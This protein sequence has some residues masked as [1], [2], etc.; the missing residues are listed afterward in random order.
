VGGEL[1]LVR[2]EGADVVSSRSG[3]APAETNLVHFIRRRTI[4]A[5]KEN[6]ICLSITVPAQI[7][8]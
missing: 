8:K 3:G 5:W 7:I 1:S 6:P 2:L 4:L